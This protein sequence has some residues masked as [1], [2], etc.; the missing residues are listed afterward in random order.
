MKSR[1]LRIV[2]TAA[3]VAVVVVPTVAAKGVHD[4]QHLY[5]DCAADG[6]IDGGYKLKV[7][8]QGLRA[9]PDDLGGLR[10]ARRI[11][12]IDVRNYTPCVD[13]IEDAIEQFG[14]APAGFKFVWRECGFNGTVRGRYPLASL[15]RARN[16]LPDGLARYSSCPKAIRRA[17]DRAT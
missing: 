13:V 3:L 2:V 17:I 12:P 6:R 7:L 14:T 8:R 5:R 16:R 11:M 9:L 4:R 15:R 1:G 10:R